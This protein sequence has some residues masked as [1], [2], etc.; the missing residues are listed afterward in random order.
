[1]FTNSNNSSDDIP[2]LEQMKRIT[3]EFNEQ[4]RQSLRSIAEFCERSCQ[5]CCRRPILRKTCWGDTLVLC[6]HYY[7]AIKKHVPHSKSESELLEDGPLPFLG[8]ANRLNGFHI[9]VFDDGPLRW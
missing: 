6:R 8:H 5:F 1:M 3:R 2:D 7:D 9:E 4:R